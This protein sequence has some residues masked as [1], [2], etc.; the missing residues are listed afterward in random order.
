MDIV[1]RNIESALFNS[2]MAKYSNT[3]YQIKNSNVEEKEMLKSLLKQ[4]NC[5]ENHT[6]V[7]IDYSPIS[8]NFSKRKGDFA[9]VEEFTF[10]EN[11]PRIRIRNSP[12][13]IYGKYV[14]MSR[15][16]CQTPLFINGVEKTCKNV[17][18]FSGNFQ[19]FF[20]ASSVKFMGCGREDID[21]RCLKGRPF[22]LEI[23]NPTRNLNPDQISVKLYKEIDIVDCY[24]VKREC[25]DFINCTSPQKFYNLLIFSENK[26]NFEKIYNIEQKT[27]LRVLHRRANM[28]RN[29]QIEVLRVSMLEKDGYYYDIDIKASSGAYIKEWVTGDFNRTIPNLGADLLELDV[30]CV[31]LEIPKE[32]I[33]NKVKL[34]R[35]KD[36]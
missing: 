2:K 32:Y 15:E 26:L 36:N 27:P 18:D 12:L 3:V 20:G 23:V 21:V 28:V 19:K 29:K 5:N 7:E 11:Q 31:D 25:K 10:G 34:E 35:L 14:K 22:V 13:Y 17:S 24:V 4:G 16:M 9:G 33:I 30:I 1:L 8:E 6:V